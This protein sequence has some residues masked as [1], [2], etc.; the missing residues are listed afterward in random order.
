M[1]EDR[2][3]VTNPDGDAAHRY[4]CACAHRARAASSWLALAAEA[5]EG[6]AAHP[7]RGPLHGHRAAGRAARRPLRRAIVARGGGPGGA[8]YR[9][10]C[11]SAAPTLAALT[12]EDVSVRRAAAHPLHAGQ[13]RQHGPRPAA[14]GPRRRRSSARCCAGPPAPSRSSCCPA[15]RVELTENWPGPP[16]PGR[17][18]GGTVPRAPPPRA[19]PAAVATVLS[20]GVRAVAAWLVV[21][22][23]RPGRDGAAARSAHAADGLPCEGRRPA[24]GPSWRAPAPADEPGERGEAWTGTATVT[25]RR[26][27]S[28][29]QVRQARRRPSRRRCGAAGAVLVLCA[30][31]VS[32]CFGRR[33]GARRP[34]RRR[35]RGRAHRPPLPEAGRQGRQHHRDAARGWRP[36]RLLMLLICGRPDT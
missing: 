10:I 18:H 17:G 29:R 26:R 33:R 6:P 32:P 30:A 16:G 20:G 25:G 19:A 14:G 15:R 34:A 13:P 11:G 3:S 28:R 22:R 27:A 8:P 9:S 2:L 12:V 35:R 1:L 5:G 31:L 36:R 21:R 7:R 4:G 24:R 23:P